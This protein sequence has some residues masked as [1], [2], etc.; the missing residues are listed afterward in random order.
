[1]SKPEAQKNLE[2]SSHGRIFMLIQAYRR[3]GHL[4]AQFNPLTSSE[5]PEEL[6]LDR[7]GFAFAELEQP[8]PSLGFCG[9]SEAPLKEIVAA[10]GSIY[11]SKIGVEYMDLG[12]PEL[13]RWLSER[14]ESSS[15]ISLTQEEKIQLWESLSKADGLE[16]F[17][18]RKYVGQTR[19]SLEGGE[20][21]VPLLLEVLKRSGELGV[22]ELLI[23]MAH[24]GRLNVLAHVLEKPYAELLR[25]FEDDTILSQVGHD[26]VKYHMG[27]SKEVSFSSGKRVLVSMAANP[28]HLES[29]DPVVLG[30][31]RA[32]Q[33]LK[34]DE[35]RKKSAR[36]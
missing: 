8:F 17:L 27:F 6:K 10:L 9:K 15:A 21:M 1:L 2:M 33:V 19:F 20:T 30:Q 5:P 16:Q 3:F 12:R 4:A 24:R 28:S 34:L 32:L 13:E 11:A 26:D 22:E 35:E 29:V 14:L 25:E 18:H 23:G 31:V 7:L 36:S